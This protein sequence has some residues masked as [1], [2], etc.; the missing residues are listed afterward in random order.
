MAG[1]KLLKLKHE[2]EVGLELKEG[3]SSKPQLKL[4]HTRTVGHTNLVSIG[5]GGKE[6]VSATFHPSENC[7][8]HI[9]NLDKSVGHFPTHSFGNIPTLHFGKLKCPLRE[10]KDS[11]FLIEVVTLFHFELCKNGKSYTPKVHQLTESK[12]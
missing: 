11:C 5:F 3:L 12:G 8:G 7:V 2:L 1:P 4:R 6:I 10:G 9:P